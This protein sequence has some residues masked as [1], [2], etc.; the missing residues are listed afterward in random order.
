MRSKVRDK[1]CDFYQLNSFRVDF[2]LKEGEKYE[3]GQNDLAEFI[4]CFSFF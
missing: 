3:T 2:V 1:N 4:A